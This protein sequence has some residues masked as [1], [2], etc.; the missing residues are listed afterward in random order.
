M[1]LCFIDINTTCNRRTL[2]GELTDNLYTRGTSTL[3]SILE[4]PPD[5]RHGDRY[6]FDCNLSFT[7]YTDEAAVV[8]GL[9]LT[10]DCHNIR[11]GR[12]LLKDFSHTI[13]FGNQASLVCNVNIP[14]ELQGYPVLIE[15][16]SS[17]AVAN[18]GHF[19]KFKDLHC[20]IG[21]NPS[22]KEYLAVL[23]NVQVMLMGSTFTTSIKIHTH[24]L[25]MT[26]L[27][28]VYNYYPFLFEVSAQ[29]D[30]EWDN[31]V[32]EI[33]GTATRNDT[34]NLLSDLEIGVSNVLQKIAKQ[35]QE[36]LKAAEND[37]ERV[38]SVVENLQNEKNETELIVEEIMV[39]IVQSKR[40]MEMLETQA[41][42]L[43][44]E[45]TTLG[46][47]ADAILLSLEMACSYAECNYTCAPGIVNSTCTNIINEEIKGMCKRKYIEFE[48]RNVQ[49]AV[50]II[51]CEGWE[52]QGNLQDFCTCKHGGVTG[53]R[54]DVTVTTWTQHCVPAICTVVE[55]GTVPVQVERERLESCTVG[56]KPVKSTVPCSVNATCSKLV[57]ERNCT[58]MNNECTKV[59]N[60][61]T[62][63]ADMQEN[64][65]TATLMQLQTAQRQLA[66]EML[67]LEVLESKLESAEAKIA[68]LD[69]A[70]G[71][72]LQGLNT[73]NLKG[74]R[75]SNRAGI[76]LAKVIDK[77]IV[78][79]D[80]I[81]FN[82]IIQKES[83]ETVLLVVTATALVPQ[84]KTFTLSVPFNFRNRERSLSEAS[85]IVARKIESI[86][87]PSSS[88]RKR[89]QIIDSLLENGTQP[90]QNQ[91]ADL[92]NIDSFYKSLHESLV[93]L[94]YARFEFEM[95]VSE[96][97]E[98]F[99]FDTQINQRNVSVD[100]ELEAVNELY[101]TLKNGVMESANLTYSNLYVIWQA[102]RN[103]V[104]NSTGT[105]FDHEQCL[106][107]SDCYLLSVEVLEAIFISTP[108]EIGSTFLSKLE[109]IR[110]DLDKLS[111]HSNFTIL[112]ASERL[113]SVL[114]LLSEALDV[115]YWCAN[116]PEIVK[117]PETNITVIENAVINL[118]CTARSDSNFPLLYKWRKDGIVLPISNVSILVLNATLADTGFYECEVS[119]HVGST[120]G[121]WTFLQVL[122]TPTFYLEPDNQ[123]RIEGDLLSAQF[124]CNATSSPNPQF[125]WYFRGQHEKN[126]SIIPNRV[127]NEYHIENPQ[128]H[129]EGWYKCEAWNEG[130]SVTSR[131]AYL[132]VVR[133]SISLLSIPVTISM[134]LCNS[135]SVPNGEFSAQLEKNIVAA[136]A[137]VSEEISQPLLSTATVNFIQN[138]VMISF[139]LISKNVTLEN[140]LPEEV[141]TVTNNITLYRQAL[142]EAAPKLRR[143]LVVPSFYSSLGISVCSVIDESRYE[144]MFMCASGK[145]LDKK[146]FTLCSK[147]IV[148]I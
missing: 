66:G 99:E 96:V 98:F 34:I 48:M 126:F 22:T 137:N 129:H 117:V 70:C 58:E 136:L 32:F 45:V 25:E 9:V 80:N 68:Q 87:S 14:D 107:L 148:A 40:K 2:Q 1:Y 103:S 6:Q 69:Q 141:N 139:Y 18:I 43:Q 83:P 146:T 97:V 53:C 100:P 42:T 76:E 79:I 52:P 65:A 56:L 31:L 115:N 95:H 35:A 61:I 93:S 38:R 51:P 11:L 37:A 114:F 74:I 77:E 28:D 106:S 147:L 122:R 75:D 50:N 59:R 47:A 64:E 62:L 144:Y 16:I 135:S 10:S 33:F 119:N 105:V 4:I 49:V 15:S 94:E 92:H 113:S 5:L 124:Q 116:I 8:T 29:T 102:E 104:I 84:E 67:N 73:H 44:N 90:L 112:D 108:S 55:Y 111:Q 30:Q 101:E 123:T 118:E 127:G 71:Q 27:A 12:L 41:A 125:R 21:L 72:L 143:K 130:G 85:I 128:H 131:P 91:C 120:K 132:A 13:S 19:L 89:R 57:P 23:R 86:I 7:A 78:N 88:S 26:S 140:L 133:F 46:E 145:K 63:Q 134:E 121:P 17:R 110:R 39:S 82:T 36:R 142:I 60:N 20:M 54:C 3:S 81:T 138:R 24:S 109:L